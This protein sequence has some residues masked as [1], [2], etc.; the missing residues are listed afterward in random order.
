MKN[1]SDIG[2]KCRTQYQTY[3][4]REQ[5]KNCLAGLKNSHCSSSFVFGLLAC[6]RN[7][8][9]RA[10]F[11]ANVRTFFPRIYLRFTEFFCDA[12]EARETCK[13]FN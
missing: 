7:L 5:S 12:C 3:R 8:V 6:F 10:G 11:S 1:I 4:A 13:L 9:L 2:A